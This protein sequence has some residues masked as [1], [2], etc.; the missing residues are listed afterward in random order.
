MAGLGGSRHCQH[1]P[2]AARWDHQGH[3]GC[4]SHAGTRRSQC[5]GDTFEQQQ[6][7]D[8]LV[9]QKVH[10]QSPPPRK[11]GHCF[12]SYVLIHMVALN[13]RRLGKLAALCCCQIPQQH[14]QALLKA[15]VAGCILLLPACLGQQHDP[16]SPPLGSVTAT[17]PLHGACT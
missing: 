1:P 6:L 3:A 14:M 16:T 11:G 9:W 10:H 4:V 7:A 2:Q 13:S 17:G 5:P 15:A 12:P 8:Q